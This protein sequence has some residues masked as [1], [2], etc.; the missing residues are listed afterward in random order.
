VESIEI[1]GQGAQNIILPST[2]KVGYTL[3]GWKES[4]ESQTLHA[5]S[6]YSVTYNVTFTAQWSLV[7]YNISYDYTG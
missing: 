6:T 5:G 1:E 3:D 7:S 4:P 2:N